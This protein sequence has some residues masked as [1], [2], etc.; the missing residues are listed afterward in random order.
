MEERQNGGGKEEQREISNPSIYSVTP[1]CAVRRK[2]FRRAAYE[3]LETD[4]FAK[5]SNDS[6]VSHGKSLSTNKSL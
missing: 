6:F 4:L 3:G 5:R 2:S 1:S